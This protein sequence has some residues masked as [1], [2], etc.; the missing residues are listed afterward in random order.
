MI[1]RFESYLRSLNMSENTITSYGSDVREFL[2]FLES[3]DTHVHEVD[4]KALLQFLDYL[5]QRNLK[6]STRRRK[7]E[8]V[9]TFY[10]A[11][12]RMGEVEA[13]PFDKFHDMPR[14]ED[15]P[16]RVLTEME[17]RTLRDV[18]RGSRRKSGVRDFAI[19]EMALQTGL[20][21]S[22]ICSLTLDDIQFSTRTTAG[23]VRVRKGK[24]GKQRMVVLNSPAEKALKD[25]LSV[26]PKGTGSDE[27]FL[28][29][30]LRPC[31]P[32]SISRLF[33]R[34]MEKAGIKGASFHSLRHTFATHTL[35]KGTNIIVVQ[36]ALG[37]KSLT[38]TQKYLH[39]LR[40]MMEKQMTKNAL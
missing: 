27:V 38:T 35:R 15:N 14:P 40:E 4:V 20:R 3:K 12:Q 18:V 36:E 30:R 33:K 28:S 22:E 9:K 37:H 24:G 25:Y 2:E 11:M 34:H 29:N 32:E 1:D 17:Y 31:S 5:T 13:G 6:G 19:L 7:M 26:R 10:R 16:M 21:R 8:A 39:F 23:Y